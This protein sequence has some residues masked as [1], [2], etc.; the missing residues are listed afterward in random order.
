MK[1][2]LRVLQN[3]IFSEL[4]K[5]VKEEEN[6]TAQYNSYLWVQIKEQKIE[7]PIKD[8]I[9]HLLQTGMVDSNYNFPR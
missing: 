7:K 8:K 3:K 4:Y 6:W 1:E 2:C 9:L 5:S